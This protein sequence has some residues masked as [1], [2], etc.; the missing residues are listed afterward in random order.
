MSDIN[1]L[2]LLPL[3]FVMGFVNSISGGGGVIG[4]PA[5]L[6]MGIP[7]VNVL[8]LNRFSDVGYV[9]GCIRNYTKLPGFDLKLTLK[10]IPILLAGAAIGA[11]LIVYMDDAL[12]DKV[13]LLAVSIGVIFLLYPAKPSDNPHK[14]YPILGVFA[15]FALGMWDGAFAMAGGTFGVIILVLLYNKSYITA[16]SICTAA[17]LPETFLSV[18]ILYLHSTL[19]LLPIIIM[20]SAAILGAHIG[21]KM[22]IKRGNKFLRYSMAA[23]AIVMAAKVLI[24]DIL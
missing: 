15:L 24:F 12:R 5:M 18:T 16:K 9:I 23:M 10:F 14:K 13:I 7:A 6:A 2:L 21:S 3:S 1:L 8:A 17:G 11:N 4:V 19:E 22:A 20:I